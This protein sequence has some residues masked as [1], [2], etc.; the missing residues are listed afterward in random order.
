MTTLLI[1]TTA[2]NY[3]PAFGFAPIARAEVEPAVQA[4]VEFTGACPASA[5]LM[6][7]TLAS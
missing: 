2:E 7:L 4:S 1:T 5:A 3:F 6:A